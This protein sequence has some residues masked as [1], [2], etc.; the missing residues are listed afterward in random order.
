MQNPPTPSPF[1]HRVD[2]LGS[3]WVR[4]KTLEPMMPMN[5]LP[6]KKSQRIK[7]HRLGYRFSIHFLIHTLGYDFL[8]RNHKHFAKVLRLLV[9]GFFKSM[10]WYRFFYGFWIFGCFESISSKYNKNLT[11]KRATS[12][13]DSTADKVS[14]VPPKL[15]L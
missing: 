3:G 2:C 9:R 12:D 14:R 10:G 1:R 7:I 4:G 13:C 8:F 6:E 11:K 15:S 5:P